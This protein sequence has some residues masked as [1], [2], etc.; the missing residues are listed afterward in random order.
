[1][2]VRT[3]ILA[4]K[5]LLRTPLKGEMG[6]EA[7]VALTANEEMVMDER[8]LIHGGFTFELARILPQSQGISF[9]AM[10]CRFVSGY[11]V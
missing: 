6:K 11:I 9:S 10:I 8:E 2:N 5:E 1:M 7:K 4:M 3:H